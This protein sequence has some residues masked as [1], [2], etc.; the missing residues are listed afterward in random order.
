MSDE[1][2]HNE[3]VSPQDMEKL[4]QSAMA[5]ANVEPVS[6]IAN[7]H[8]IQEAKEN[9]ASQP[10]EKASA[11]GDGTNRLPTL[12]DIQNI[13]RTKMEK[14]GS[15]ILHENVEVKGPDY[16]YKPTGRPDDTIKDPTMS[17][18]IEEEVKRENIQEAKQKAAEEAARI[19]AEEKQRK[20]EEGYEGSGVVITKTTHT[21]EGVPIVDGMSP[22]Q[23]GSLQKYM[24]GMEESMVASTPIRQEM[25]KHNENL[26]PLPDYHTDEPTTLRYKKLNPREENLRQM[27]ERF[28]EQEIDVQRT[29]EAMIVINKL[30]DRNSLGLTPEEH[31]KLKEVKTINLKEVRTVDLKTIKKVRDK[32]PDVRT[33]L[34][35]KNNSLREIHVIL[36]ISG[37]TAS[38]TGCSTYEIMTL[39]QEENSIQDTEIKWRLVFEKMVNNDLG[40]TT[41]EQFLSSTA[42]EDF[43]V[44][45]W[46]I[47]RAT[48]E[49][50][51]VIELNCS[52][53]SCVKQNGERYS[54]EWKY[55]VSDL[56]R[57]ELISERTN[58]IMS[59]VIDAKTL[60]EAIVAYRQ[61]PLNSVLGISLPNSEYVVE[62]AIRNV[63]EFLDKTLTS[64]TSEN[65]EPHY[66]Q[67]ASLAAGI[68]EINIPMPDGRYATYDEPSDIAEIIYNLSADDLLVLTHSIKE[69]SKDTGFSFG[70]YDVVC[71]KCKHHRKFLPM[72]VSTILF[73]RNALSVTT[74]VE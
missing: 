27:E 16:N 64:L 35:R 4:T 10:E 15:E 22:D 21:T 36:P 11:V 46:A 49:D 56:L 25:A 24:A 61:S 51:D 47:T 59:K 68:N 66:R 7:A 70:F 69:H 41:F 13:D 60:D 53:E 9:T 45:I 8:L 54:Y 42:A 65:L 31:S 2:Q 37:Y 29:N 50:E 62:I 20:A 38:F 19:E 73:Y 26:A 63:R 23:V 30:E 58:E 33:A 32:K 28:K 44:C 39:Q 57:P 67:A 6:P 17:K 52:N 74:S 43:D 55:R 72:D 3:A 34:I 12:T 1:R 40:M 5:A 18:I 71:P 14:A 48:F